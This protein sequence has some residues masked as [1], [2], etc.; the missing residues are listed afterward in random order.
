MLIL[1]NNKFVKK[2]SAN[3]SILSEAFMYGFGVFE[4]LRT[5]NKQPFKTKEHINRLFNSAK[6]IGLKI[7]QRKEDL[8]KM[9][10][11]IA[12]KSNNKNQKIKIIAIK[13]KIIIISSKLQTDKN[14]LKGVKVC[15][16]K[17]LRSLPEIKSISYIESYFS[18]KKATDKGYFEAILTKENNEI[19][20]GAYSNIFWFDKN[21]LCTRKNEILKG[22]T[23]DTVMKISPF[24][25]KFE[26]ITLNKLLK[27]NEIFLTQTTTGIVPVT[28]I[29]KIKINKGKV[30]EKTK[31][32]NKL[33]NI[34]IRQVQKEK[35][36]KNA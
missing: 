31:V 22:I 7:T 25:L 5:Y 35:T 20:E 2:K 27:K 19:L 10:I 3:I 34:L 30:G 12:N 36:E 6:I 4:T 8:E 29:N 26:N 9:I 17:Q 1:I 32:L 13:D 24:K 11:K 33:F 16:I 18:H 28:Q 23:A 14:I 21:K 15:S